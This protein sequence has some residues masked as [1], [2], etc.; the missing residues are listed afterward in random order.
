MSTLQYKMKNKIIDNNLQKY[1]SICNFGLEKENLRVNE[2]GELALTRHPKEFGDKR[3]N[4]YITTDFAESQIEMVTPPCDTIDEVYNFMGAINDIVTTELKNEYLWPQSNPPILPDESKIAVSNY[5]GGPEEKYRELL[6]EKYGKKKQLISGVHFNFSFKD[7]FLKILYKD[8]QDDMT[9]Q[10]FKNNLYLNISRN[11]LRYRWLLV[12]LTAASPVFHETYM[13]KCLDNAEQLSKD[14]YY[15]H[16]TYSLR[17]SDCGYKNE[18]EFFVSYDS[19]DEY[20]HDIEMAIQ[21]GYI[22]SEKEYYSPI[23]LKSSSG[24][25][26]IKSLREKGIEYLEVRILDLDPLSEFGVAKDTLR[27]IH[28]FMIYMMFKDNKHMNSDDFREFNYNDMIVTSYGSKKYV[29]VFECNEEVCLIKKGLSI[30]TEV[31]NTLTELGILDSKFENVLTKAKNRIENIDDTKASRIVKQVKETS[32][33]DF[34]MNV[35]KEAL[36]ISKNKTFSF[37]GF[38]DMELSTQILMRDSIKRGLKV[39]VLDR[40]ENFISISNGENT[41][42]VKQATKTSKDTY[43]TA[44]VM[45]NKEVTKKVLDTNGI[46]VPK[47]EV[48]S[49]IELAKADFTL[50]KES[51]IVIKPKTTNFGL[52]ISI[53]KNE[54][55]QNDYEKALELAFSEDSSILIEEF[56]AGKEYRFLVID[57]EVVGILHRVPANVTGDGVSSITDLVNDKN[58]D[59]LRGKGYVKPLEKIKLGELE[60]LFLKNQG[61]NFDYI[62]KKNEIVYLRENSNIST[63]GDS[64]DFTDEMDTSYKDI[65]IKAAKSVNAKI[66]GI[67]IMIKDIK[68]EANDD[69]HSI[70]ELNFNPAIH[71]HC[72]PY[73]GTNRNVGEKLL[74]LLFKK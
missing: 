17:N 44:L 24:N 74:N 10:E 54:F 31:E 29:K 39:N 32:F 59:F 73:K 43:I 65:A 2:L 6:A 37:R 66:T 21:N 27:L 16:N 63:G 58:K 30:I 26:S 12:Y 48:Y 23:R 14:S 11:F 3:L 35:A 41:E 69:N 70:I 33:I 13:D 22:S 46:R 20:S 71:I 36:E 40:G 5:N 42:Y 34:H 53:F 38:E 61:L 15:I 8:Y 72:Y 1:L 51:K 19:I 60:E 4:P 55:T 62:P 7:E 47:G 49:N 56:I 57:D 25:G 68:A 18:K 9:F 28:A 64:I 50:Y 67:D 45:E 52:G